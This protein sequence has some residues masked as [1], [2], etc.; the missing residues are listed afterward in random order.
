[1][2]MEDRRTFLKMGVAAGALTL[3]GSKAI[4]AAASA[5]QEAGWRT[6]IGT[7]ISE[8]NPIK[9]NIE[10]KIPSALKGSLYRNGP[11]LFERGGYRK[12]NAL[13]GDGLVQRLFIENGQAT[14]QSRFVRTEKFL[15]E[16][17]AGKFQYET[18]TTR[19]PGTFL[20]N[21][22]ADLKT[23]A[24]V[25]V[26]NVNGRLFALDEVSPIYELEPSGLST[27]GTAMSGLPEGAATKAHTKIDGKTGD[28]IVMG[29]E[30][31]PTMKIHAA[32]HHPDGRT[33]TLPPVDAP[34][35]VY[36]HD[37]FAT[38]NYLIANLQ[39][40]EIGLVSFL[41]GMSSFTDSFSWKP[42]QGNIVAVIPKDGSAA[43]F[44]EAPGAWMW[45][46]ANA[47]EKGNTIIADFA[48]YDDPGHFIGDDPALTAVMSGHNGN[49]GGPGT[50]R[51]YVI[52]LEGNTLREDIVARG[53]FE[54]PSID[55]RT[56][57]HTH[58]TVFATHG[59]D[60]NFFHTG[61]AAINMENGAVASY[62]FGPKA[63]VGEPVFAPSPTNARDGWVLTQ[64]LDGDA[65]TTFFAIFDAERI[66]DGPIA[67]AHLTH[68]QP[69][70]FHGHWAPA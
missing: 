54:F 18:W 12:T 50:M 64:V 48:G 58:Q 66:P 28:W 59:R 62:D 5:P 30:F 55:P 56:A 49:E 13:D 32:I 26:Y 15:T 29:G 31:G 34:R 61:L 37:F 45:H 46:A 1:M 7:S 2:D 51:R 38:E 11:G 16:E 47:Y 33:T 24:G 23:Q 52:D 8:S 63:Y 17:A 68:H 42:E 35:Q 67:V 57:C 53:A 14:H 19:A 10:G 27:L 43:Q 9:L 25:T 41:G 65:G 21:L 39:P 44:F 60:N 6:L 4:S 40:A 36:T 20:D 70:S 69:I 22:G 3:S